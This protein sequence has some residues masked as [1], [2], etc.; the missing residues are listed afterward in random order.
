MA[1]VDMDS[2]HF[3]QPPSMAGRLGEGRSAALNHDVRAISN[4]SYNPMALKPS[5]NSSDRPEDYNPIEPCD[6]TVSLPRKSLDLFR[7]S[8]VAQ[9]DTRDPQSHA[10]GIVRSYYL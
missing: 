8:I 9:V 10:I 6:L 2:V 1:F 7:E 3:Y 5:S 4:E